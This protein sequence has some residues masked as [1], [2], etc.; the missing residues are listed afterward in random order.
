MALRYSTKIRQLAAGTLSWRQILKNFRLKYYS[1]VQ[2]TTA[3]EAINGT[4]L[5]VFTESAGAF[6]AEVAAQ[7]S[8]TLAGAAGSVDTIKIGGAIEILGA[9][10]PFNSDLT[11][12][13][14]DVAAAINE[15][16]SVINVYAESSGAVITLTAPIG[17]GT[18]GNALALAVTTTTLTATINGGSSA[19]FG[20]AGSPQVGVT[21][22]NGLNFAA[23]VAG[24][25]AKDGTWQSSAVASGTAGWFR[26]EVDPTDDQSASTD[27]PRIDG[28]IATAGSDLTLTSTAIV[29]GSV[30]TI[31]TFTLTVPAS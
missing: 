25:F 16:N 19:V 11:T 3:D 31:G 12:T 21:S 28:S 24:V 18:D 15:Y 17:M 9:S 2:P 8:I 5:A 7:A 10:V 27:F 29:A 14:A 30:Q 20:G 4:L 26:I 23:P 13:A 1:G 6:T 22:I